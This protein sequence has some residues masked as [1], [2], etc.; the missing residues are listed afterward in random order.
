MASIVNIDTSGFDTSIQEIKDLIE[1]TDLWMRPIALELAGE[2][3]DRIHKRGIASDGKP[4]GSY[5]SSYLNFRMK[6]KLGGDPK[7]I[8]VLTRK[9][10]NSWGAFP[11]AKGWGVGF[12]D[13]S[14]KDGVT[15]LKKIQFMEER[16]DTKITDLTPDE[17]DFVNQRFNEIINQLL[18]KYARRA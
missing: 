12:V 7:I 8:M 2:M 10:S 13:D 9:L 14:A 3:H 1:N 6:N 15:S 17:N 4:I 11:T 5:S 16:I 18:E